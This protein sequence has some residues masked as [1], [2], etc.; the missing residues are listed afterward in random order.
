MV[1][2]CSVRGMNQAEVQVIANLSIQGEHVAEALTVLGELA[3]SARAAAGNRRFEVLQHATEP[4][5]LATVETWADAAAADGHMG[6]A[7]VASAL[8]RLG[9]LL[10]GPPAIERF[11][12]A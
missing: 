2:Q 1:W 10:A 9:P 12:R 4:T 8:G 7:Y 5:R 11:G 6:S 3:Q